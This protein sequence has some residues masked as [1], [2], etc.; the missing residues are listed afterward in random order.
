MNAV[1]PRAAAELRSWR[2]DGLRLPVW[3]RDDDATLPTPAL[4]RL[5]ALSEGHAAPLHLAVIPLPATAELAQALQSAPLVRVLPHGWQHRNHAAADQKKAEFGAHRPLQ[6]M[7]EE[8]GG[9]WRR[10]GDLFGT[11]ALPLFTPPWNRVSPKLVAGLPRV[12]LQ[13]VSTFGPRGASQAAPGVLQVNTH[14][15]P[16]AWHGGGGLVDRERLDEGIAGALRL[17]RTGQEDNSEPYGLLTHHLVQDE[18]TWAFIETLLDLLSSSGVAIW[19][20]PLGERTTR[21]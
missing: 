16:I 10:I 8:V 12:G 15:D 4:D 1:L 19:T 17:R 11:R 3:W 7:L 21:A 9:G 18:T 13:G 20:A 6:D 14:L 2:E 5:I